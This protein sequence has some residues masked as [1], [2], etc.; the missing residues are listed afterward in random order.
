MPSIILSYRRSDS[1]VIAGR[2]HDR[3]A[4]H[5]GTNSV[6]MDIDSIP[7][8]LDFREHI[9]SALLQNDIL[10]A[11]IGPN[12]IGGSGDNSRIFDETDPVRIE[13]ETALQRSIP[14]VPVLVRGAIMPKPSELPEGLKGLAY[15]N[16]A[17]VDGGRDF[18]QHMDRLIRSMDGLL[19]AKSQLPISTSLLQ[20]AVA[21]L[22]TAMSGDPDIGLASDRP[23]SSDP[24]PSANVA[25]PPLTERAERKFRYRDWVLIAVAVALVGTSVGLVYFIAKDRSWFQSSFQQAS[26][27]TP[28][29]QARE[30]T[31]ST[32]SK[33][34]TVTLNSGLVGYWPFDGDTTS[35]T[36]GTTQDVSG[37]G[38]TGTLVNMSMTT[39]PIPGKIGGA[40]NFNGTN[41]VKTSYAGISGTSARTISMWL[42]TTQTS[43]LAGKNTS[44]LLAYG[45]ADNCANPGYFLV[46]SNDKYGGSANYPG[47]SVD[48]PCNAAITY[49]AAIYD[50][51][52]RHVVVSMPN[53]GTTS[54]LKVYVDGVLLTTVNNIY[55]GSYNTGIGSNVQ[56]GNDSYYYTAN[57]GF[58]GALDDVRIYDRALS[59]EEVQQLYLMGK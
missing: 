49:N 46:A 51:K 47:I 22:P 53:S 43:P 39:S 1:D 56:I 12:W 26:P 57:G 31:L 11:V 35:W 10:I 18:H 29:Q 45:N 5:Y 44:T 3:L 38:N 33:S 6:F 54:N 58:Q 14:V 2:M 50:N 4:S 25:V 7:F 42:K 17:I 20:T 32:I 55:V 59:P 15:R 13:V 48:F 23:A 8:G 21:A 34:N 40:L 9:K 24:R 19:A 52:W 36:T 37:N 16:A 30:Q 27:Q 41:S 28:S